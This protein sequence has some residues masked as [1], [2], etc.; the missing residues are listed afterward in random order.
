VVGFAFAS[1]LFF[2]VYGFLMVWRQMA[3]EDKKA[4]Q[5]A[6]WNQQDSREKREE[7][8]REQESWREWYG[9]VFL[10]AVLVF[11]FWFNAVGGFA[12]W[13]AVCFLSNEPFNAY[14]WRHLVAIFIA[15]VGVT[16]HLPEF[17]QILGQ[18][19]IALTRRLGVGGT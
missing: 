15:F 7:A 4:K 10:W 18:S 14:G 3:L 9:K 17:S 6:L 5:Q 13:A 11:Q 19:V 12:G 2:G 8:L 1:A 16:G